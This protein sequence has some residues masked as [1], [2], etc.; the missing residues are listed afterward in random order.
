MKLLAVSSNHDAGKRKE[1]NYYVVLK[2]SDAASLLE[3]ALT[4]S[5]YKRFDIFRN[6]SNTKNNVTF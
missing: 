1:C 6:V 4:T 2:C 3:F 5:E